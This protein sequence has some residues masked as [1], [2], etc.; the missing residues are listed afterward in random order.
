M[1]WN[2]INKAD[3]LVYKGI[4]ILMIV[5]HN[6]MDTFPQPKQNEFAFKREYFD[7]FLYLMQN[8]PENVVRWVF[9]YL[10]HFGVQV[11]IFLSAYGLTKK[12]LYTSVDYREFL[13]KRMTR[14][15]PSFL[16]ALIAWFVLKFFWYS[17]NGSLA[18]AD[19]MI[20]AVILKLT[21]VSNFFPDYALKPVGPW[22]FLPFIV[23]FYVVYPVLLKSLKVQGGES[24]ILVSLISLL[25][26][27]SVRDMDFNF[28]FTILPYMPGFCLG[29]YMAKID[30]NRVKISNILLLLALCCFILGNLYLPFW[31]L[32]HFCALIFLVVLLQ[33]IMRLFSENK[34]FN[35]FFVFI[36]G[37]SMQIFFLHG[38]LRTPFVDWAL[39]NDGWFQVI[40]SCIVYLIISVAVSYSFFRLESGLRRTYASI[41]SKSSV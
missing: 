1:Q 35:H 27:I 6:F 8:D 37:I 14:L 30:E 13:V 41:F 19:F 5:I 11:F 22:W 33:L 23:Q 36:G 24:L 9:A 17:L 12:Y 16:L 20:D 32:S 39:M 2:S 25:I 29:I 28:Y 40:A 10:G 7:N 18:T 31:Y 4:A 38:F 21:L 3:T 15:Y 26:V 34:V